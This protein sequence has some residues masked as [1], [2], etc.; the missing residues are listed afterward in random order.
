MA[1]TTGNGK[2]DIPLFLAKDK[3]VKKFV[4]KK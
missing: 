2:L 1:S 3:E 4:Y